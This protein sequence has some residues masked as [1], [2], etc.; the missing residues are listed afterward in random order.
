MSVIQVE[1]FVVARVPGWPMKWRMHPLEVSE[2]WKAAFGSEWD[3]T[4]SS[5]PNFVEFYTGLWQYWERSSESLGLDIML[6][7]VQMEYTFDAPPG[8]SSLRMGTHLWSNQEQFW[9]LTP[10]RDKQWRV[11]GGFVRTVNMTPLLERSR[12]DR[13][14]E[15]PRPGAGSS[16]DG[17]PG[18]TERAG[19]RY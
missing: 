19:S 15:E 1:R 11:L 2:P 16:G 17:D 14:T 8:I 3:I 10:G 12:V 6:C 9:R 4:M 7:E 18:D 13:R 5:D